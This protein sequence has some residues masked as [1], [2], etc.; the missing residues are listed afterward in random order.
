MKTYPW[1]TIASVR[2]KGTAHKLGRKKEKEK[3]FYFLAF[4]SSSGSFRVTSS[5]LGYRLFYSAA[6]KL[7]LVLLRPS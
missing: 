1:K 6:N 2:R 5:S 4:F 3:Y 7:P